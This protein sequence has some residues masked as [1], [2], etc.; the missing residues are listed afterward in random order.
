MYQSTIMFA[1]Q[2][3]FCIIDILNKRST[4][5]FPGKDSEKQTNKQKPELLAN[6]VVSSLTVECGSGQ[7]NCSHTKCSAC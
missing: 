7:I 2:V 6:I 1:V 5:S 3:G 4:P